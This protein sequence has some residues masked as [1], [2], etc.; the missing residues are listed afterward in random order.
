MSFRKQIAAFV[1]TF[2]AL[3]AGVAFAAWTASGTGNGYAKATTAQSLTFSDISA[4]VSATLYPGV[5][6]ANYQYQIHNPNPYPVTVSN[7]ATDSA[8]VTVVAQTGSGCTAANSGVTYTAPGT[9]SISVPAGGNSATQTFNGASMSN[10][11][12]DACQGATFGLS[13]TATGQSG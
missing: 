2:A 13:L 1:T 5:S 6:G 8:G 3:I 4:T 10:S 9:V 7:V 12:V 11:S